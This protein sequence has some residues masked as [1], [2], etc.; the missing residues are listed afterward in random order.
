VQV[1]SAERAAALAAIRQAGGT[2]PDPIDA[3]ASDEPGRRQIFVTALSPTLNR[4]EAYDT[5]VVTLAADG[6]AISVERFRSTACR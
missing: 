3:W 2:L 4:G 6:S 5:W 1:N